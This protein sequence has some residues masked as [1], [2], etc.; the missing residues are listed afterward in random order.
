M[1]GL[2]ASLIAESQILKNLFMDTLFVCLDYR[3][4]V[5]HGGRVYNHIPKSTFRYNPLIHKANQISK[6]QYD[7]LENKASIPVLIRAL[8]FMDNRSPGATIQTATTLFMEQH[9]KLYERD[10]S[11]PQDF[12]LQ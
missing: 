8:G 7:G 2:P 4:I 3:N 5:A 12:L 10:K 6:T 9:C 11:Y 1:Y